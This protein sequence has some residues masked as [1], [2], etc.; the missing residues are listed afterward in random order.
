VRLPIGQAGPRLL[1][2][3]QPE[4]HELGIILFE[5]AQGRQTPSA[6]AAAFDTIAELDDPHVRVLIDISMLMPALPVTYLERLQAGGLREPLLD[7]LRDDWRDPATHERIMA[8]LGAGEIPPQLLS[9]AMDLVVRFGRSSAADLRP[10]LPLVSGIHLKFWDLVD[11]DG[12]VSQ[13]IRDLAPELAAS[14]YAG[15]LCSEWGGHAWLDDDATV[16]TRA[17]LSLAAAALAA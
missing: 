2:K 16:M 7:A 8:A 10:V 4:L 14:G 9:L 5:E 1:R 11:D 12:R 6:E 17:H 15:T 13:P 3:L